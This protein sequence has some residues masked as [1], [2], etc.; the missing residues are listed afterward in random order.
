MAWQSEVARQWRRGYTVAVVGWAGVF[1]WLSRAEIVGL[2]YTWDFWLRGTLPPAP[3][4]MPNQLHH[5]VYF[6]ACG[7][8]ALWGLV[9]L[10]IGRPRGG[11]VALLFSILTVGLYWSSD[12]YGLVSVLGLLIFSLCSTALRPWQEGDAKHAVGQE[13]AAS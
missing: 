5:P 8:L 2:R 3:A 6:A 10:L 4:P 9:G 7:L 13:R 11:A 1:V 12:R